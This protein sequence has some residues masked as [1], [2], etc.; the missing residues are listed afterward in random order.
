MGHKTAERC[1]APHEMLDVL[2][3]SHPTHFGN[4]R[5]IVRIHFDAA[6]SHDVPQ[7]FASGTPKVH[8]SGFSLMLKQPRMKPSPY[9]V[10][11]MMTLT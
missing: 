11:M 5:D 3:I 9:W 4:G 7:K 10:F 1:E 2:D 8:F 6:L